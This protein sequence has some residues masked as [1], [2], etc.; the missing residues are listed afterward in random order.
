MRNS[1]VLPCSEGAAGLGHEPDMGLRGQVWVLTGVDGPWGLK[2]CA[3][4]RVFQYTNVLF[5]QVQQWKNRNNYIM[6]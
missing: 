1:P 5:F 6:I 2:I 3:F 4:Q